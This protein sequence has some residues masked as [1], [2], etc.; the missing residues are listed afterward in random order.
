MD[1]PFRVDDMFEMAKYVNYFLSLFC[2][3]ILIIV[4]GLLALKN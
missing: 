3:I 4:D 1:S 2:C